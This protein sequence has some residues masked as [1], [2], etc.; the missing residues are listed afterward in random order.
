[1]TDAP[2]TQTPDLRAALDAAASHEGTH[3]CSSEKVHRHMRALRAA[4]EEWVR[5]V[6]DARATPAPLDVRAA[7]EKLTAILDDAESQH[8]GGWG[9][10]VTTVASLRAV[11]D[12]LAAEYD[13]LTEA[14]R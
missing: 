2:R 14:D 6:A 3:T 12:A 11:R 5:E 13:R 8:P 10:D 1:M 4:I 9:P 7:V